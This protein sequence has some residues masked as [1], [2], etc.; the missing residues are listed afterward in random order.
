MKDLGEI[1]GLVLTIT[2]G[3]VVIVILGPLIGALSGL[4]VG[5]FFSTP[6]LNTLSAF[7]VEGV[8]M[9]QLGATLGFVGG[10]FKTVVINGS[11]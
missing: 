9:W 11:E 8:S 4:I 6:I 7:G 1:V 2:T 5:I 3:L 10:F